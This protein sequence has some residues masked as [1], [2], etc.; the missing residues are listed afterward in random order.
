MLL[1]EEWSI[2]TSYRKIREFLPKST[3]RSWIVRILY[4]VLVYLIHNARFIL[5]IK[6]KE[7]ETAIAIKLNYIWNIFMLFQVGEEYQY[8]HLQCEIVRC[9]VPA[10]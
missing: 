1:Q 7:K 3:S 4:F 2:W 6:T 10:Y 5:N 9:L 8:L